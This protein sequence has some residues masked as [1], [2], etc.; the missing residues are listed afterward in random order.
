M[1]LKA[2]IYKSKYL[3]VISA[4]YNQQ[5]STTNLTYIKGKNISSSDNFHFGDIFN[6]FLFN[7]INNVINFSSDFY[8]KKFF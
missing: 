2:K 5:H 4:L 1:L 8:R 7:L 3:E 6:L